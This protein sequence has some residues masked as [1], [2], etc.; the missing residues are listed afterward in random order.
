LFC[1]LGNTEN[2]QS[3]I[4]ITL[5]TGQ[6]ASTNSAGV[7][8]IDDLPYNDYAPAIAKP[9]Y[10]GAP[11]YIHLKSDRETASVPLARR[12]PFYIGNLSSKAFSSGNIV[13]D[14]SLNKGIPA[15]KK[16]RIAILADTNSTVN[17]KNFLTSDTLNI[18][19]SVVSGLNIGGLSGFSQLVDSRRQFGNIYVMAVPVS[20]GLY[21]SNLLGRNIPLGANF[22]PSS[23]TVFTKTWK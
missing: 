20:Y 3:G 8:V 6:S 10:E 7:A 2:T 19:A 15:G 16:C 22:Y 14:F 17:P 13:I 12:S 9:D 18:S 1:Y 4:L 21:N 23:T 5:H 11:L